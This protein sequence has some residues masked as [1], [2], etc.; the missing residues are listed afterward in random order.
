ML[1]KIP[2]R[3][4]TD[5]SLDPR[6]PRI[7]L[8]GRVMLPR[9]M[10]RRPRAQRPRR[11]MHADATRR[12]VGG[13]VA[14]VAVRLDLVF[15]ELLQA[16]ISG[17]FAGGPHASEARFLFLGETFA[18][19][20][21]GDRTV[22]EFAVLASRD[23]KV[24]MRR[25]KQIQHPRIG[26]Q[27]RHPRAIPRT[28]DGVLLST[29]TGKRPRLNNTRI[30]HDLHAHPLLQTPSHQPR[31]PPQLINLILHIRIKMTRFPLPQQLQDPSMHI[32]PLLHNLDPEWY[33]QLG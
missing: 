8:L 7:Q 4:L 21:R 33:I 14:P 19:R 13:E 30:M 32:P 29:P 15:G 31:L 28:V 11:K 17:V 1:I 24:V 25:V 22:E 5:P 3:H 10:D 9:G 20:R 26:M 12:R 23:S 27:V 6:H 18:F 16:L 2:P